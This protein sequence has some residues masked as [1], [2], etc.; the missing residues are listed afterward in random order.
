MSDE[1]KK[2][3]PPVRKRRGVLL[4]ADYIIKNNETRV[5]LQMKGKRIYY[6]F[7]RYE[8]Y[9]YLDAPASAIPELMK[10]SALHR[11][12]QIRPVR[13]EEVE[14][15]VEGKKR[16]V[17]KVY[18]KHPPEIPDLRKALEKYP[19][20]EFNILFGRRYMMDHGLAPLSELRYER[21]GRRLLKVLGQKEA[22]PA[23]RTMTFDIETYNPLGA[24]RPERDPAIMISYATSTKDGKVLTY[25]KIHK[26]FVQDCGDEKGMLEAFNQLIHQQD[27]E[28]LVGYNSTGFDLPYL[29]ARTKHHQMNL[30]L[31]RDGSSFRVKRRGIR[32]VASVRGRIYVDLLPL[33]RF[34]S[35]IG[36]VKVSRFSLEVAYSEIVGH[37]SELKAGMERLDIWKMWDDPGQL[38][39][40][41]DYSQGDA[42]I[43]WE[44]AQAVLPLEFEMSRVT[45]LPPSDVMGATSS[46]LVESLL[47]HEAVARHA[48]VPNRPSDVEA[49]RR[50]MNPIQGAFVR[51]PEPGIY[52]NMVVFDFRGLYPSIIT[53]HNIDPFTLNCACCKD[54]GYRSPTGAHFCKKHHGLIPDVLAKVVKARAELKDKLKK[55]EPGSDEYRAMFARQQSLKILANSYYGYLAFS[56]SRYY[57]REAAESVTAWG[58]H[59]IMQ[60]GEKAEKAGFKLLY[61]DTDSCFLLMGEKKKEDVLAWMKHVNADLPAGMELELE[62]FYPR[63]VFVSKKV[64]GSA[65]K[66]VGSPNES[67]G[68]SKSAST[69]AKKKYALIDDK[70]RIKIRGFELVRRDWS[71]VARETQRKVLEAILKDGSKERAVKIVREVIEQIRSGKMPLEKFVIE[72]QLVKGIDGYEVKSPELAAALKYNSK[73]KNEKMGQGAVVRFVITRS[74][75]MNPA[76][77]EPCKKLK[78]VQAKS[79]SKTSV[80]DKAEVLEYAKDYDPDYYIDHQIVPTVLKILKELGVE[81][82]DLKRG[83]KQSGLGA[84]F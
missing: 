31:G 52:E 37:T 61:Q 28:V 32:D 20:W 48:I 10:A 3:K 40:L 73:T 27:P 69:G 74:S 23:F 55:L 1:P 41:A 51:T 24:P 46:Q 11:G 63:G 30:K 78:V 18:G 43:T 36:A 21:Q 22:S 65:A 4:E 9:F 54:D 79:S 66:A 12:M 82:E 83:G 13:I 59:Y 15:E 70:G 68:P 77:Y 19:A 39:H 25:K 6:L 71:V 67:G 58:R 8:P 84:F 50:E 35:F 16:K 60:T 75:S 53:A 2:S 56:R 45:R 26:P 72:T 44:L 38:P 76:L 81:E 64:A 34:L 5:R 57:S 14:R 47:M 17:L 42:H 62:A 7:D 49:K 80:S 33:L 29:E